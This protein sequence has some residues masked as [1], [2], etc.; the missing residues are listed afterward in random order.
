MFEVATTHVATGLT[1]LI[2]ILRDQLETSRG[3]KQSPVA[4]GGFKKPPGKK[5]FIFYYKTCMF[6]VACLAAE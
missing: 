5:S 2:E 3:N 1:S 4:A 6:A